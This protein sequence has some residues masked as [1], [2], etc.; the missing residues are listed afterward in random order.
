[1]II[2]SGTKMCLPTIT[3]DRTLL[4]TTA[5]TDRMKVVNGVG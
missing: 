3:S 2:Y 4:N 1:M 5:G